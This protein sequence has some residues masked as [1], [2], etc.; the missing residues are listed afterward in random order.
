M[1]FCFN[2]EYGYTN[3]IHGYILSYTPINHHQSQSHDHKESS[4]N[5]HFNIGAAAHV[6]RQRR[7]AVEPGRADRTS[8]APGP[9]GISGD[10]LRWISGVFVG[11]SWDF[12]GIFLVIF[13][14]W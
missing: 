12:P 14:G 3:V 9:P 11:F 10:D 13:L 5:Q 6:R 2:V 1:F 8:S 7:W 4:Q